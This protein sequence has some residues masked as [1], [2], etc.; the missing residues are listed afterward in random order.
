MRA[1]SLLAVA[2]IL[3]ALFAGCLGDGGQPP[4][5]K[6]PKVIFDYTDNQTV[7]TVMAMAEHRY[8]EM[9]VNC[10]MDGDHV[11]SSAVH[12]YA[13][14]VP[15]NASSFVL[16]VTIYDGPDIYTLNTTVRLDLSVPTSPSYW[17]QAEGASKESNHESPYTTL[18]EWVAKRKV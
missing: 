18:A 11:D 6:I 10:T 12:R 4:L 1:V 2:I 14:I 8:D 3:V 7:I 5:A 16:N 15:V 13:L 17:L 9:V